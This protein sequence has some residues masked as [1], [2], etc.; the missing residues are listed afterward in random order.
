[1]LHVCT[2]KTKKNN[3]INTY[4]LT[5]IMATNSTYDNYF[6]TAGRV[7]D[8]KNHSVN[9]IQDLDAASNS[10]HDL[11]YESHKLLDDYFNSLFSCYDFSGNDA[12][13]YFISLLINCMTSRYQPKPDKKKII[14]M[15]GNGGNG[16]TTFINLIYNIFSS[17]YNK[18]Y[19]TIVC[20]SELNCISDVSTWPTTV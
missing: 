16:K 4:Y 13:E 8:L 2:K 17:Y 6:Y 18:I 1:M 10:E 12:K 19:K 15:Y 11:T 14:I 5:N 20:C 3:K 7:L 9:D